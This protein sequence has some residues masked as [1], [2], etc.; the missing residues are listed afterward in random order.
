MQDS[1]VGVGVRARTARRRWRPLHLLALGGV[2]VSLVAGT[3][4]GVASFSPG[5]AAV[6]PRG[7]ISLTPTRVLDTRSGVGA[8]KAPIGAGR[9][10]VV[11]LAG[12]AGVPVSG[13]GAVVLNL[14][15]VSATASTA[16]TV[17]PAGTA[18]PGTTNLSLVHGRVSTDLVVA[19][20]G[21]GGRV[22][23]YNSAGSAQVTADVS[24]WYATGGNYT[25]V[26]PARILNTSSGL[27]APRAPVRAGAHLD[28]QVAGRGGVPRAGATAV[29]MTVTATSA[30]AAT[31]ITAYPARAPRPEVTSL[32]A[33]TGRPV[34]TLVQVPLGTGGK[35]S[36]Y[37]RAGSV[38]L[39]ADVAG[40]F[41]ASGQYVPLTPA[42]VLDTRA[43]VGAPAAALSPG[44]DLRLTVSGNGG[45]SGAGVLAAA[46]AV[47]VTGATAPG[48]LS[49]HPDG[50]AAPA[51]TNLSFARG[52]TVTNLAIARL[53]ANGKLLIHN[54]SAGTVQVSAGV[55]GYYRGAPTWGS[56]TVID[57]SQGSLDAVSCPR[58]NWCMAVDGNGNAFTFNGSTWQGPTKIDTYSLLS[59]SCASPSFCI[60]VDYAAA[61]RF[62]G[63]RWSARTALTGAQY[64]ESVSCPSASFCMATDQ[65]RHVMTYSG[66]AWSAPVALDT[67]ADVQLQVSC[68][69]ATHCVAVDGTN[70]GFAFDGKTWS[71]PM[72]D[73][74]QTGQIARISCVGPAFCLAVSDGSSATFDGR[75]WGPRGFA[76][77][78]EFVEYVSCLSATYCRAIDQA[79][80]TVVYDGQGWGNPSPTG[81]GVGFELSCPTTTFC[82]GAMGA[83]VTSFNGTTWAA[84]A[85][86]DP[87]DSGELVSVSCPTPSFCA[88]IDSGGFAFTRTGTTWI[89]G[90]YLGA[91]VMFTSVSCTASTFCVAVGGYGKV[92]MFNGGTW[93][94][95]TL[96][97]SMMLLSVSCASRT[98]CMAVDNTSD[99]VR[100]DGSH[101]TALPA[102]DPGTNGFASVS[103]A[104]VRFCMA[105]D[106]SGHA[107][108][109]DGSAWGPAITIDDYSYITSVSCPTAGYCQAVDELGRAIRY[110]GGAWHSPQSAT[111]DHGLKAL[112]CTAAGFCAAIAYD[113]YAVVFDGSWSAP[114]QIAP[115]YQLRAIA[116]ASATSCTVV[117]ARG[118][119]IVWS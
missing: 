62:D 92:A 33:A 53:A 63:T 8:P 102:V 52:Q 61:L 87:N 38:Q 5:R 107:L 72:D 119:A 85:L 86:I 10:I 31:S 30:T 12:R 114:V 25:S 98:F 91:A 67:P 54:A 44:A 110:D 51:I 111:T 7:Y 116:C 34:S 64:V 77:G 75:N 88:A 2:V 28:L 26:T 90:P 16:L 105:V 39:T 70:Q 89:R 82:A 47:T 35:V 60:A 11:Q 84:P 103:C 56:P 40:W 50:S 3:V 14:T 1:Q 24:G 106:S 42:L 95:T 65:F 17:Y 6:I 76:A 101:W 45:V 46:M 23:I 109:Y 71:A 74:L 4:V 36:L 78:A 73:H 48:A 66:S 27:G 19:R 100:F 58:P 96:S 97:S 29:A 83:A 115:P 49:L 57:K 117:G 37:N 15:G 113:G 69:S 108:Q 79:G 18:R 80:S 81:M 55:S 22:A 43:G 32:S 104:T 59:V 118:D 112:S 68:A 13:V 20:L 93:T 9:A 41:A 21:S 99:A 94:Q